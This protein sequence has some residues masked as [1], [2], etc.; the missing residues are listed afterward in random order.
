LID[1]LDRLAVDRGDPAVP[2]CG[3]GPE[4]ACAVTADWA[5]ERDGPALIPRT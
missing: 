1:E 5:C 2:R 4:I 3:Y